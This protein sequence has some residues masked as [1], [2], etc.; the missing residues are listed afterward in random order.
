MTLSD[1]ARVEAVDVALRRLLE[2]VADG[3]FNRRFEVQGE[4]YGDI[5]QTTWLELDSLRYVERIPEFGNIAYQLTG[6]GWI[7]ALRTAAALEAQRDRAITLRAAM[8]DIVKGRPLDGAITNVRTLAGRT[9][10]REAWVRNAVHSRLLQILWP[11]DH[12]DVGFEHAGR[13]IRV[14][15]RFGSKRLLYE[16]GPFPEP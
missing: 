1:R 9:G 4:G 6:A 16:A 13:A 8:K 14:P 2:S 15:A 7:A 3:P 11:W 5:P 10:L 12:L